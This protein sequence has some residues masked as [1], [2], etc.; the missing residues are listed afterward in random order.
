MTDHNTDTNADVDPDPDAD[1]D[2]HTDRNSVASLGY[3]AAEAETN[4]RPLS[5]IAQVPDGAT[6]ADIER[7][8]DELVDEL[9][10]QPDTH[11]DAATVRLGADHGTDTDDREPEQDGGVETEV[12]ADGGPN[13][14]VTLS[15][16]DSWDDVDARRPANLDESLTPREI[17]RA[18]KTSETMLELS[19]EVRES[20]EDVTLACNRLDLLE[21]V[22]R[23]V[24]LKDTD[25][26]GVRCKIAESS[27]YGKPLDGTEEDEDDA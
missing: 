18:A 27:P 4:G 14:Q 23:T 3:V 8:L 12:L 26:D 2:V 22:K 6:D 21:A 13:A 11:I 17:E 7:V 15:K 19:R 24:A 20:R 9:A 10:D 1:V 25:A 16:P 5:V